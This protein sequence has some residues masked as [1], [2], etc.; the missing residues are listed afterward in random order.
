PKT[1]NLI[2]KFNCSPKVNNDR[3]GKSYLMA[4]PV[5][6]QN[7]VYI[8]NGAGPDV[9][10]QPPPRVGNFFCID[11]TKSGDVSCKN[12]KFDPKAQENKDSALVWHFGGLIVPKPPKGRAEHFGGT[13][14][15]AA[16]HDG[17]VYIAEE[18]G[19]LQCLDANTGQHYWEFDFVDSDVWSSPY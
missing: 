17:L 10:G 1:G 4:T 7:K 19:Y 6:Y 11:I 15:T 8:G 16:I 9:P 2:W 14:S 13:I 18:R 3:E 5:V 12:E